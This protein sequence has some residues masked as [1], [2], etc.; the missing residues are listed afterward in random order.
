[1][2]NKNPSLYPRGLRETIISAERRLLHNRGMPFLEFRH[3]I[4]YVFKMGPLIK[5]SLFIALQNVDD[6]K[7]TNE[8]CLTRRDEEIQPED[9][10]ADGSW[11]T[12]RSD[13]T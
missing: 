13:G 11:R 6:H 5:P 9:S 12:R 3:Q 1:M 8:I 7:L 10:E 4:E 2:V